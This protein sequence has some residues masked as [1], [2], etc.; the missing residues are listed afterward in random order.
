MTADQPQVL[1]LRDTF[2]DQPGRA[3]IGRNVHTGDAG[4]FS[5]I[6]K[7][8]F[9]AQFHLQRYIFQHF[10]DGEALRYTP[11]IQAKAID[12]IQRGIFEWHLFIAGL[13]FAHDSHF[14]RWASQRQIGR[15]R[16]QAVNIH[17]SHAQ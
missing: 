14:I 8:H 12:E 11:G 15:H 16:L 9:T 4:S 7:A 6:G 2:K 17:R 13:E 5:S 10:R 1:Q 3:H